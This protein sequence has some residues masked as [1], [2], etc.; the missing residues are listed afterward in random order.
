[1]ETKSNWEIAVENLTKDTSKRFEL[2]EGRLVQLI[3]MYRNVD[4]QLGQIANSVNTRNQ[5]ELSDKTEVNLG[6]HIKAITLHNNRQL[7]D[8]LVIESK[9]K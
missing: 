3:K 7:E 2:L 4:V 9:K 5:G 8:P 1:M 6:E